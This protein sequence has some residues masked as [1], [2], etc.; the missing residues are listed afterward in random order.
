MYHIWMGYY[1]LP[2]LEEEHQISYQCINTVMFQML[3]SKMVYTKLVQ[4]ILGQQT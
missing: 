2:I 3:S 4:M 1:Y